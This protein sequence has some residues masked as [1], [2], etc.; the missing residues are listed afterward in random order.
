M[1]AALGNF[2]SCAQRLPGKPA[3]T[4]AYTEPPPQTPGHS[5]LGPAGQRAPLEPRAARTRVSCSPHSPGLAPRA[6]ARLPPQQSL[7]PR[8]QVYTAT[9]F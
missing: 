6:E 1:P 9:S 8:Y 5:G 2:R 3:L 4:V 7:A